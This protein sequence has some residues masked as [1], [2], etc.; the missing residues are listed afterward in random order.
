MAHVLTTKAG[1]YLLHSSR[2]KEMIKF[3]ILVDEGRVRV[4]PEQPLPVQNYARVRKIGKP[5][6]PV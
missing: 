5:S 2:S 6:L 1:N 4:F 3:A